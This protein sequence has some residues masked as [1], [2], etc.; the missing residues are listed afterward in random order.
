MEQA[1]NTFGTWLRHQRHTLDLTQAELATRIGYSVVTVRKLERNEVRPSRQVAER[2]ADLFALA[3]EPR[4]G[5]ITL[6]RAAHP[7]FP[8]PFGVC[9]RRPRLSE[10]QAH[11]SPR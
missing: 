7:Q 4:A 5:L 10:R 6:A 2:L 11:A 1:E 8:Q 9:A 3:A